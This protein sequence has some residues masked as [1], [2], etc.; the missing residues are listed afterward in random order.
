MVFGPKF[1]RKK[2]V[3]IGRRHKQGD[4]YRRAQEQAAVLA[5]VDDG[6]GDPPA[7]ADVTHRPAKKKRSDDN[8]RT[9]RSVKSAVKREAVARKNEAVA[10]AKLDQAQAQAKASARQLFLSKK[11]CRVLEIKA[12]DLAKEIKK[13]HRVFE[14]SA[15]DMVAENQTKCDEH[16]AEKISFERRF[17][18][19]KE[20]FVTVKKD[21]EIS[22]ATRRVQG[23]MHKRSQRQ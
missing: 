23:E 9:A 21:L 6:D 3:H 20:G 11:Q 16:C 15:A 7:I 18:S 12:G 5:P 10:L 8:W 22:I 19:L 4:S 14:D 1:K 13:Q 17:D 2:G